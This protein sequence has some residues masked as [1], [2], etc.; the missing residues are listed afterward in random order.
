MLI[1]IVQLGRLLDPLELDPDLTIDFLGPR[2]NERPRCPA[3]TL[4][5]AQTALGGP[6]TGTWSIRKRPEEAEM[7]V[8]SQAGCCKGFQAGCCWVIES[9]DTR[10]SVVGLEVS[11]CDRGTWGYPGQSSIMNHP[12]GTCGKHVLSSSFQVCRSISLIRL[13]IFGR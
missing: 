12:V 2:R 4:C 3:R 8:G 11:G 5:G 9:I 10:S 13:L 6:W 1:G 7:R